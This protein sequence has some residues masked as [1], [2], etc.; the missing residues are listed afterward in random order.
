[1]KDTLTK[2]E[3]ITL[4][5]LCALISKRDLYKGIAIKKP[6]GYNRPQ[7]AGGLGNA[8]EMYVRDIIMANEMAKI[9]L[10]QIEK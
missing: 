10:E 6:E 8:K 1:M 5:I 3:E 9:F 2:E 7:L 4:R